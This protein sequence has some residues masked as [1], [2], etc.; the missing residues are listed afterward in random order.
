MKGIS[1]TMLVIIPS[2]TPS[3]STFNGLLLLLPTIIAMT[4]M[5]IISCQC[6]SKSDYEIKK[7]YSKTTDNKRKV[8]KPTELAQLA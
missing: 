2:T 8:S 5:G 1:P 6:F 4:F 7:I 3:A